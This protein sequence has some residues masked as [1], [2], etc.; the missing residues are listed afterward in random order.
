MPSPLRTTR[1]TG[2][3]S[4]TLNDMKAL[5]ETAKREII[6]SFK[7]ELLKLKESVDC[8]NTKVNDL[9]LRINANS[10]EISKLKSS[11]EVTRSTMVEWESEVIKEMEQR[12]SKRNNLIVVGVPEPSEGS[13]SENCRKDSD[14]I[15]SVCQHLN[16]DHVEV[17]DIRRIGKVTP[18][19]PR[20]VRITCN[21][22]AR[23]ELLR[24]SKEL[25]GHSKF[26][27]VFINIDRTRLQ[28]QQFREARQKFQ[29][30]NRLNEEKSNNTNHQT[31]NFQRRF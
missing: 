28:Q 3:N 22:K 11:S 19:R 27:N 25:R 2:S 17:T 16:V 20:L 8:L 31:Q 10:T 21:D 7:A 24:K 14:F 29:Q 26:N 4:V 15:N 18:G 23:T 1:S 6:Q 13:A 5:L 12:L 9:E 30:R